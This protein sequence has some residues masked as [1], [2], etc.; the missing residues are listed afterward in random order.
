MSFKEVT[1]LR[2]SGEIDAALDMARLDYSHSADRYS[3]SAL[4]W[5]LKSVCDRSI[6]AGNLEEAQDLFSEMREVYPNV[7]DDEGIAR[8]CLE[9]IETRLKPIFRDISCALED[10]K[11]GRTQSAY[12]WVTSL[13]IQGFP[14]RVMGD[15]AWIYFYYLRSI[16]G[17]ATVGQFNEVL[18]KYFLLNSPRPSLAHS[19]ILTLALR[20]A[21]IQQDFRLLNF[22]VQWGP[23][24][25]MPEDTRIDPSFPNTPSLLDRT[26]KRCF[27]DRSVSVMEVISVFECCS[28]I[29]PEKIGEIFSHAYYSILYK[30]SAMANDLQLFFKDAN[31]YVSRIDEGLSIRNQYHSKILESVLWRVDD[32]HILWFKTFFEKWGMGRNFLP[33][34]W[35]DSSKDGMKIFSLVEKAIGKYDDAIKQRA[36]NIVSPEYKPLLE[37]AM[38]ELSDNENIARR[39]ARMAFDEGNVDKAVSITRELIKTHTGKFYFWS[40]LCEYVYTKDRDLS[41]ACCA[42][43][44]LLS[45]EEMYIGKMHLILGKMLSDKGIYSE[46]LH[47]IELYRRI[48]EKNE[49]PVRR[50]YYEYKSAIPQGTPEAS[51]NS[52]TYR[53]LVTQADAF[54]YADLEGHKMVLVESRIEEKE[55]GK[56]RLMFYL[57]DSCNQLF[58]INPNAFGLNRKSKYGS[59]F[60]VK[61]L[62]ENGKKK[63]VFVSPIENVDVLNY[64]SA[65]VDRKDSEKHTIHITGKGFKMWVPENK[66][67]RG[68]NIGDSIMVALNKRIKDGK[69]I[70]SY[71]HMKKSDTA[72]PLLLRYSGIIRLGEGENGK[73]GFVND[74]YIHRD[75]LY[76][77][78]D[79][80]YVAGF[81][82]QV[83]GRAKAITLEKISQ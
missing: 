32:S 17:T 45:S 5:A 75:Y 79:E 3:A 33:D 62:T 28:S 6:K 20:F 35:K 14:D 64:D 38:T 16:T 51:D 47:E 49:W 67:P 71:L 43:S 76:G 21:G 37:K 30:D 81:G 82:I 77:V 53:E 1:S 46:A 78:E 69:T 65:V 8:R 55:E 29:S 13:N 18:G 4:F 63:V 54:V 68:L 23:D 52:T 41:M 9:S 39:L 56:K 83:D 24:N 27:L 12:E 57:Y 34:D 10:A 7:D 70:Y 59:C 72:C 60:E 66:T 22:M 11:A 73:F 44:I 19:M 25:F 50:Q 61:Y 2:K 31:E 48:N 36:E 40:E 74:V 26:V 42:K 80:D 15:V 58:R